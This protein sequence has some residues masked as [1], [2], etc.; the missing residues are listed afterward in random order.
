MEGVDTPS[1]PRLV[2]ADA[3]AKYDVQPTLHTIELINAAC[4]LLDTD[5]ETPNVLALASLPVTGE[6]NSFV[7]TDRVA[8]VRHDLDLPALSSDETEIRAAQAMSRH[9]QN[10]GISDRELSSWAHTTISHSGAAALQ[11]LV[12][13]D[14]ILDNLPVFGMNDQTAHENLIQIVETILNLPD[15]WAPSD[16]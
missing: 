4:T 1:W 2:F 15:P 11:E 14:D 7:M 10:G 3:L 8:A 12:M 9:W 13:Y 5:L 6:V 16:S